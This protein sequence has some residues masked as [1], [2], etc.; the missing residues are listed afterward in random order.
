[1]VNS[2][3]LLIVPNKKILTASITFKISLELSATKPLN[4]KDYINK[5][6][7]HEMQRLFGHYRVGDKEIPR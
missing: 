3:S 6:F 1:M 4:I 5:D 7:L 2:S